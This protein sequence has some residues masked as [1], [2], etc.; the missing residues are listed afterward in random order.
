MTCVP[1]ELTCP[2]HSHYELWGSS[3]PSSCTEPAL[4]N[5]GPTLCQ[6]GCQCDPGFALSGTDCVPPIQYGCSMGGSYHPAGKVFWAGEHYE[7]FCHCQA[8]THA[9]Y[10]SPSS[11]EPGQRCGTLSGIS[12]CH[13]LFPGTCQAA[14][15]SHIITS[16]GKSV[17]FSGT[18]VSVFAESC[19]STSLLPF[20]RVQLGKE[21]RPKQVQQPQ[22][23]HFKDVYQGS[24]DPG[25]SAERA[26]TWPR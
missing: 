17:E 11:C 24:W 8:S 2:P 25:L 1:P 7:Q 20:F 18:C 23:F 14:G 26:L 4:L 6:H 15:Y 5:S 12:G 3:C 21:H 13:P 16:D 19:G 10:C 22:C 9:M